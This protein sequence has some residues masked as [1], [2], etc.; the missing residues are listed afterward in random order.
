MIKLLIFGG[1]RNYF[2]QLFLC[3]A[4]IYQAWLNLSRDVTEIKSDCSTCE[5]HLY[6]CFDSYRCVWVC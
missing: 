4:Y 3:I 2:L 1:N 6:Y 5:G